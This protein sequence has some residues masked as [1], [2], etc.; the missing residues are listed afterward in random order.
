MFPL[1]HFS[2][3]SWYRCLKA[4]LSLNHLIVEPDLERLLSSAWV[5]ADSMEAQ[6]QRARQVRSFSDF[7]FP[8]PFQKRRT[9]TSA[10]ISHM[11]LDK[12]DMVYL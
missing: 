7:L 6:V 2:I 1:M 11:D 10:V 4:L 9:A 12:S 3:A 5:N 8:L